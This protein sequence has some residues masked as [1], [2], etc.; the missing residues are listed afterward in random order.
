MRAEQL[1]ADIAKASPS[2]LTPELPLAEI[3]GWD[4]LKTVRL[5]VKVE[6]AIQRELTEDELESLRTVQSVAN[7]LRSR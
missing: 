3:A 1:I 4:S 2:H 5:V 7:V 6:E